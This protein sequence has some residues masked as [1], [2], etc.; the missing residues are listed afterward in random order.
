MGSEEIEIN[1]LMLSSK[2]LVLS[3]R[4]KLIMIGSNNLNDQVLFKRLI[5]AKDC[6]SDQ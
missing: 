4:L 2:S 3:V 5:K 6:K 1:S